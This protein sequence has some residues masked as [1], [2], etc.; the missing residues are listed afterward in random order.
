MRA[1]TYRRPEIILIAAAIVFVITLATRALLSQPPQSLAW[2]ADTPAPVELGSPDAVAQLQARLRRNP[3]DVDAYAQLGL[4]LLQRVRETADPTLYTQA[5]QALDAALERDPQ[6]LDALT[7]KGVLALARHHFAEA[8]KW[9]QRAQA[10]NPYR[11]ATYG[12]I[13]DAQ[14]ELGQYEAATAT[15][16]KMVDTRPDLRSYSRVAYIR[17]LYGET[18]GAIEAMQMAVRSGTP[19]TEGTLWTQYQLGNL[20]FNRGDL[21]RAEQ[22][23][24][25]ALALRPDYAY[26]QAG[27]ARVRA[28]QGNH[29]EAIKRYHAIVARLPLPEFVIALGE[30]YEVNGQAAQ[31][32]AQYD[33]VRA[34]QQLNAS[35]GVNVDMELALFNADHGA[36]PAQALAQAQAAYQ[37]R[38]SIYAADALAWA[39]YRHGDY[40][41][42]QRAIDEALHL[43]TRD[44]LLHFH[45]GMIANARGDR[46]L[47]RQHLTQAL[48]INPYFSVRYAPQA[49]ALLAELGG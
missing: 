47:A 1:L 9:G 11:A 36:D 13:G 23:Y 2:N 4:A 28:A 41:A 14:V 17:E 19:G 43:G 49:R 12:I 24:S 32:Q 27:I 46:A 3:Q 30:L 39:L 29:A 44:A 38:P 26:A 40:V 21:A 8:L 45:A 7:G 6:H 20:F 34:M 10:Q 22:V 33:L 35:A 31:A 16:Q 15:I 48:A 25:A 5:E 42:A 18:D 37:E